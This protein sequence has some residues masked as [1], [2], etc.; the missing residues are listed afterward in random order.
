MTTFVVPCPVAAGGD[1]GL[2]M[3][4]RGGVVVGGYWNFA[5][6]CGHMGSGKLAKWWPSVGYGGGWR[7][8]E[9]WVEA[10][11]G[12]AKVAWP[13]EVSVSRQFPM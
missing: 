6:L 9:S 11:T 7:Q 5:Y 13:Q 10:A 1:D 8:C 4:F 3:H 12:A 2:A